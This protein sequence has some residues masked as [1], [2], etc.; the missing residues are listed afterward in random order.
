MG[1]DSHVDNPKGL[2]G[3]IVRRAHN[4][5]GCEEKPLSQGFMLDFLESS[6]Y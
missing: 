4:L 1:V 2:S 5:Q 3:W 6:L